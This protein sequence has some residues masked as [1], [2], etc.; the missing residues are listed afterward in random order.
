V[1]KYTV[2]IFIVEVHSGKIMNITA[3]ENCFNRNKTIDSQKIYR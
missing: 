2:N 1:T 3:I